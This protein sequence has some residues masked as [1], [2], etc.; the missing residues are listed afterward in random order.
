MAR[1][2]PFVIPIPPELLKDPQTR[3]FF[4]YFVRWAY[5]IW[6]RTGG[7]DDAVENANIEEKYPWELTPLPEDNSAS[8]LH[9]VTNQVEVD[10]FNAVSKSIDYV[11][12]DFDFVNAKSKA[13]I[14]LPEYPRD[15]SVVIVRNGDGLPIKLNG[16]GRLINGQ[17]AGIIYRKGTALTLQYFIDD[18]EWFAR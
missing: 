12:S 9:F 1:V 10:R 7:G 6:I 14:T 16:N 8:P 4:E 2:D 13:T 3:E 17:S 18:N 11:A 5:D 15:G